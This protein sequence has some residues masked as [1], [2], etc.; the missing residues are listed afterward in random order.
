[1]GNVRRVV[2]EL[3]DAERAVLL[4]MHGAADAAAAPRHVLVDLRDRGVGVF[5]PDGHVDFCDMGR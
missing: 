5:R 3:S 4:S 2:A 1:M